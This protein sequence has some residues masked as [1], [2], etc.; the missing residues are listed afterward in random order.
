MRGIDDDFLREKV[1]NN[2]LNIYSSAS[3][4]FRAAGWG[5][6][7]TPIIPNPEE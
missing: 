3:S 1:K 2:Y 4:P 7:L 5:G 6:W